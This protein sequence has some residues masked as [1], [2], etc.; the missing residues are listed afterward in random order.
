MSMF[1]KFNEINSNFIRKLEKKYSFQAPGNIIHNKFSKS[2]KIENM[3]ITLYFVIAFVHMPICGAEAKIVKYELT[4]CLVR[5]QL[6][7][8]IIFSVSILYVISKLIFNS[9]KLSDI[10]VSIDKSRTLK[11]TPN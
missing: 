2:S 8:L 1:A 3:F 9:N 7:S 5:K 4:M 10:Y 6:I 11:L